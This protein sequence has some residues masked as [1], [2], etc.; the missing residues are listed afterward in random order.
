MQLL[1][2]T[3]FSSLQLYKFFIVL[4][5]F[6]FYTSKKCFCYLSAK[7]EGSKE[8]KLIINTLILVIKWLV[9][10]YLF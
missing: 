2:S 3:F 1:I 6:I 10:L 7:Q 5:L 4:F 9:C 8:S